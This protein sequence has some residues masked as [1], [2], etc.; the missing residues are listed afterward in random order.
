MKKSLLATVA[1]AALF[2]GSGLAVAQGAKEQPAAKGGNAEMQRS[3]EPKAAEPK[4]GGEMKGGSGGEM[5]GGAD[6]KRSPQT[7]GAD[8]K[9]DGKAQMKSE[10]KA[11]GKASTTG[12]AAPEQKAQGKDAPAAKTQAQDN[13]AQQPSRSQAQDSKSQPAAKSAQDNK[14]SGSTTGQAAAGS[15]QAGGAVSLTT[16]QKTKIRTT[17]IQSSSAPKVSRSSINFNISVGTVVPRTVKFVAVP[18]TLVEIHP[19]WRGY[20]YFIVDDEI[21]IVE[22]RTLKIIAVVAV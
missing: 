20:S 9:A 2:A 12:Q 18:A 3:A 15:T 17:V 4:A 16:E 11:D 7:T 8:T 6:V 19:A 1:A 10:N 13:K 22:P 5:K 21:I 14:A